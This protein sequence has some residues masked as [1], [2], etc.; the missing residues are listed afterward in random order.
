MKIKFLIAGTLSLFS[1][2]VFAQ[3]SELN[4]AQ[5]EYDKYETF[6]QN[7]AM[8]SMAGTSINTAKTSIDKASADSK[9]G[10]MPQTFALKS[11]I[12]GALAY[13][14][15]VA[16][17]SMPLYNTSLEAMKKAKELDTKGEYKKILTLLTSIWLITN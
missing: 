1:A 6:R 5:S 17:T 13:N 4:T 10:V 14:D 11:A 9:T 12:Y 3:K 7:K 15:T 2:T 16:A 8:A